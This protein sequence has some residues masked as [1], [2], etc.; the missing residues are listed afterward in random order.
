MLFIYLASHME[1]TDLTN[2]QESAAFYEDRYVHGYMGHWSAFEKERLINL[3]KELNLGPQ[4]KALDFGCGRGIFTSVLKEALPGWEI[5]GC[6]ISP[7]AISVAP[8]INPS[9]RFFVLGDPTFAE[10]RFDFIHSHH[11]LEHTFDVNITVSEISAFASKKCTMLHSLPCNHEGS[12]DYKLSSSQKNGIDE[13]TGKFFFEDQAHMRRLSANQAA[14]L[15]LKYD[16]QVSMEYY[17][18]Q[19]YGA[20]KWISESDF[21]MVLKISNPWKAKDISSAMFLFGMLGKLK[22]FWFSNFAATAFEAADRGRF[23]FF[24]KFLQT[25]SLILFFW[26]AIPI[27]NWLAKKAIDEWNM[28]RSDKNGSDLFLILNRE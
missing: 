8:K 6:D 24:K 15:F 7:Q 13:S 22:I 27:R 11:V 9:I 4:G 19:Y 16:F 10:E 25:I 5:Y 12:L 1:K 26:F 21:A 14:S 3:I 18:N 17:A 28:H 20:I 23:Y 2:R